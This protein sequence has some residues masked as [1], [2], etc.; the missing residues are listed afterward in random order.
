MLIPSSRS[1]F[2]AHASGFH[3]FEMHSTHLPERTKKSR[4]ANSVS[5]AAHLNSRLEKD[6]S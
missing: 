2:L 5:I 4:D 1:S 3:G 6:P